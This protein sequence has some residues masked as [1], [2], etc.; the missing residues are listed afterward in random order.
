VSV[1]GPPRLYFEPLKLFYCNFDVNADPNLDPDPAFHSNADPDLLTKIM[2]I[3]ADP[4]PDSQ[5]CSI[6]SV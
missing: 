5:P 4:D 3:H 1:H 2:W 6:A